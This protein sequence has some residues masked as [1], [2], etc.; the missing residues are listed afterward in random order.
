MTKHIATDNMKV[1]NRW[2]IS[3]DM[4]QKKFSERF[5]EQTK[6]GIETRQS[7]LNKI[8]QITTVKVSEFFI[9]RDMLPGLVVKVANDYLILREGEK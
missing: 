1:F 5:I 6:G 8:N 3:N 2:L 7:V 4:S 9:F